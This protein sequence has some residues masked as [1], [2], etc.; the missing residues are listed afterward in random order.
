MTFKMFCGHVPFAVCIIMSS[1]GTKNVDF[2]NTE[3]VLK[4]EISTRSCAHF[5]FFFFSNMVILG[6]NPP[7]LKIVNFPA[8]VKLLLL[9]RKIKKETSVA[10]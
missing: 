3:L 9:V 7:F 2:T 8:C 5:F 1:Q 10:K 4:G 6:K